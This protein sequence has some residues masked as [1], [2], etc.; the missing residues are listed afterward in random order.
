MLVL[1]MW[2]SVF[3]APPLSP[4]VLAFVSSAKE[5]LKAKKDM[6]DAEQNL[7]ADLFGDA[8]AAPKPTVKPAAAS[9]AA[10]AAA[11]SSS[12]S[13]SSPDEG[14][15]LADGAGSTVGD[16]IGVRFGSLNVDVHCVLSSCCPPLFAFCRLSVCEY[17][18]PSSLS[19][20][21]YRCAGA[22]YGQEGRPLAA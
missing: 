18:A 6:E 20:P 19:P 7:A 2:I 10:A 11:S 16:E 5:K 9:A 17:R 12:S 4:L 15:G 8:P 22:P 3:D 14:I 21:S 1:L 13:S